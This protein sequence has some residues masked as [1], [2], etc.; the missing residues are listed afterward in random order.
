MHY[1]S[2]NI[3]TLTLYGMST[4]GGGGLNWKE[5]RTFPLW[6]QITV[7]GSLCFFTLLFVALKVFQD[8]QNRGKNNK[9]AFLW[10]LATFCFFIGAIIW[11]FVRPPYSEDEQTFFC[12]EC[13][14][15]FHGDHAC[16]PECGHVLIGE[17]VDQS[18]MG[19]E[20]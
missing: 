7:I 6:I 4:G 10:F 14:A 3:V 5:L 20:E 13:K 16:C 15:I 12:H 19:E 9:E 2:F 17:V 18:S 8:A 11:L 1:F